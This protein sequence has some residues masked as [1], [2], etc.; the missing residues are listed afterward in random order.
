MWPSVSLYLLFVLVCSNT[1]D[2]DGNE[3]R[4]RSRID[5]IS[6]C[7]YGK[8]K[9]VNHI[10][11]MLDLV[12]RTENSYSPSELYSNIVVIVDQ[13]F[14]L[15]AKFY[16]AP[17]HTTHLFHTWKY[18]LGAQVDSATYLLSGVFSQYPIEVVESILLAPADGVSILLRYG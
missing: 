4:V 17:L 15:C 2:Y 8:M 16:S 14:R 3:R 6:V 9:R 5:N 11:H 13:L 12:L 7:N 10:T 18:C 1:L